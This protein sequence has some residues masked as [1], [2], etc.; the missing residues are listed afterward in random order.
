VFTAG[1]REL[2]PGVRMTALDQ[3]GQQAYD[4]LA[5]TLAVLKLLGEP[6]GSDG[7][8][9]TVHYGREYDN[10]FWDGTQMVFGDGD[11][12]YFKP[13]T[14]PIDVCAHELG[15]G[16][17]GD[18]LEYQDQA[19]ALNE[20]LSDAQ[21]ATVRQHALG[22]AP[23]DP[24]G[25]LIGAGLFTSSVHGVALRDMLHP[26]TAYDDPQLGKDDQP[27]H[28]DG[29]VT[30]TSDNGGVHT[31][32]GI[33]NRAF[34]LAAQAIGDSV[35]TLGLWRKA[36]ATVNDPACTFDKFASQTLRIASTS[37]PDTEAVYAAWE[38]VGV[39]KPATP[40][41]S[42]DPAPP[43]DIDTQLWQRTRSWANSRH[44]GSN[45][46]AATAVKAWAKDK[47]LS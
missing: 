40:A 17:T 25:W 18:L 2:E 31:N 35:K 16:V 9:A 39:L 46:L 6:F 11:G 26:G 4:G 41:P 10:A 14:G 23:S 32:S 27:A 1:G 5:A 20:S 45:R 13:F 38:A 47:G 8:I 34:A 12:Q 36:L 7:L 24:N 33:P 22:L 3:Q 30:T 43:P 29:Y 28:M 21:G 15:H 44:T 37:R 19:G 42:P